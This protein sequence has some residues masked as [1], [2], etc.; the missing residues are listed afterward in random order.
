MVVVGLR[1][2]GRK[3]THTQEC[4]SSV[5]MAVKAATAKAVC[6]MEE[7]FE[8]HCVYNNVPPQHKYS[9]VQLNPIV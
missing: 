6:I 8:K 3:R 5:R 1:K 9:L 7:S 4:S 2:K